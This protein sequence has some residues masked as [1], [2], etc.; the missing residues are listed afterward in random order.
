MQVNVGKYTV[1][2]GICTE[3]LARK[4]KSLK[5]PDDAKSYLPY[6]KKSGSD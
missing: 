5:G 6:P 1:I 3:K 2:H 4:I